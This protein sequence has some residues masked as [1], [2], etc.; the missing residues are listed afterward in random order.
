MSAALGLPTFPAVEAVD[1]DDEARRLVRM[2]CSILLDYPENGFAERILAVRAMLPRLPE[3]VARLLTDF[4]DAADALGERG[5]QIAYVDIFD[6]TRRC[7]LG[8]TYYTHGDTRSRGQALIGFRRALASAGFE[9]A[10]EELPDHLPLLLEAAALDETGI[11]ED[12]IEANREGIEVVRTALRSY[13]AP[14]ARVLDALVLTLPEPSPEVA[15]AYA[16]LVSQGPPTELVGVA[17]PALSDC[18]I[19]VQER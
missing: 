3:A 10:R 7:A 16:R 19:P 18:P 2:A 13:G 6:Q 12:L 1:V 4:C 14:W 9:L 8:L 5:L 11:A 17:L 15:A